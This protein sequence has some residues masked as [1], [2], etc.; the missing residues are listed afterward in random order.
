MK[1]V[2][3][4]EPMSRPRTMKENPLTHPEEFRPHFQEFYVYTTPESDDLDEDEDQSVTEEDVH[5]D[6]DL[7]SNLDSDS[8]LEPLA[9]RIVAPATTDPIPEITGP[10]PTNTHVVPMD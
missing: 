7:D 5:S 1:S 9:G 3:Q 10:D 8:G 6:S 4:L 2:F